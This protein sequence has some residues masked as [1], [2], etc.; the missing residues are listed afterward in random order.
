MK[1][2][3]FIQKLQKLSK[4]CGND[5]Q[6]IMAD[7]VSVISPVFSKKYSNKKNVVITDRR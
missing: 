4:K 5:A 7:G 1:L 6:V 3:K 2:K